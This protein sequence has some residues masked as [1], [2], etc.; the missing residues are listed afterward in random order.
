MKLAGY[1]RQAYYKAQKQENNKEIENDIVLELVR[2]IRKDMPRAGGRKLCI[3]VQEES[4]KNGISIGRDKFF[5]LLRE[6][7]MLVKRKKRYVKTT[8]SRGFWNRFKNK[9][10]EKTISK[11]GEVWVSDITYINTKK[12]F[13]YLALITDAFSR[14]IVGY[15]VSNSLSRE[16][17]IKALQM[18]FEKEGY[19][20]NVNTGLCHHSDRGSQYNSDDY[21]N[22]LKGYHVEISMTENGDP[23]E[24]ALAERM[25]GTLKVEWLYDLKLRD[26]DHAKQTVDQII[27]LYNNKRLHSALGMKTPSFIHET[28]RATNE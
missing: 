23:Y 11:P 28:H 8:D 22:L 20:K 18:A 4:Q 1:S 2:R 21:V 25:N 19:Q 14:K 15:D 7:N 3:M 5:G 6:H 17:C 16:I 13:A 27:D 24:N 9:V 26:L 12:G 10:K